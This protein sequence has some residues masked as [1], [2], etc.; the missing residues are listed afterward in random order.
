MQ[1]N[2]LR[3][4]FWASVSALKV[5]PFSGH[6][7]ICCMCDDTVPGHAL[8]CPCRLGALGVAPPGVA[9]AVGSAKKGL[10]TTSSLQTLEIRTAP[11]T[12]IRTHTDLLYEQIYLCCSHTSNV[13]M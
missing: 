3:S 10:S 5:W 9:M 11:G 13:T 2:Q 8:L 12:Y 7:L 1:R 6:R 4:T